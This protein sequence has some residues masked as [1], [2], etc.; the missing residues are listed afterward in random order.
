MRPFNGHNGRAQDRE[1]FEKHRVNC[2]ANKPTITLPPKGSTYKWTQYNRTQRMPY[3]VYADIECI[4][5]KEHDGHVNHKPAAFGVLFVPNPDLKTS[6][7]PQKYYH[8]V[9][10]NCI[11]EGLKVIEML[12]CS[13]YQWMEE[14]SRSKIIMS[15]EDER[16]YI[17]ATKCYLCNECFDETNSMKCKVRDHDHLSLNCKISNFRGAAHQSCNTKARLNRRIL[18]IVMHNFKSEII[19]F[20]YIFYC[21]E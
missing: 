19:Y 21:L 10:S 17:E 16:M 6:A 20:K 9:G 13:V 7:L 4:L 2:Y 12:A 5:I 14:N 1:V 8:F 11:L 3:V 18:P 15:N